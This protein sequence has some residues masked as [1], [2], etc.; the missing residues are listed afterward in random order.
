MPSLPES[1]WAW[2]CTPGADKVLHK[3]KVQ[4]P[5]VEP[6]G[7]LVKIRAMG[8]CH[9]DCLIRD[10]PEAPA[11]FLKEWTLGHE[12]AGEIIEIGSEVDKSAFEV[13]DMVAIHPVPGCGKC[14]PC[15]SGYQ[16]ICMTS[17][18]GGYGLGY[19]GFMQEYLAVRADACAKVPEGVPAEHACIAADALLTAYHAV[20]YTADVKP[21]QTIAITGLG[22]LGLNGLQT[23]LHLGVK[24]IIAFDK[25]QEALDIAIRMGLKP[26]DAYC[27]SETQSKPIP[28]IL[29]EKGI[30]IDTV[31]DFVGHEETISLAQQIIRPIGLIVLV[32]L[33]SQT[34]SVVPYLVTQNCLT[35][36]GSFCGDM[37][38][39]N[40]VLQLLKEG[41]LKPETS[42][43]SIDNMP[44][45]LRDLDDGKIVGRRIL[46]PDW[47]KEGGML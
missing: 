28:E 31:V 45:T 5:K 41:V 12:G 4:L 30:V 46:L 16:R 1:I 37:N 32:G 38:G 15:Q 6:N 11:Q 2:K 7:L 26:E 10:L 3:E 24:R 27:T 14:P 9:S 39:L 20:K 25:R 42:T 47:S 21:D 18:K 8:V 19:D 17:G 29:G 35:I 40:E 43:D 22:G 36:K 33:L 34:V 13:G 23:A 44:Q